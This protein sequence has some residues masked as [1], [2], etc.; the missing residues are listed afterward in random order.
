MTG[1]PIENAAVFAS[2]A[3]WISPT[4]GD[5]YSTDPPA[6]DGRKVIVSDVDHVWPKNFPQWP[7]KSFTRGLN[8]AFMDLYGATKIGDKEIE[9]L[10]F[11][12]DW[13][14]HHDVTR[15]RMGHTRALTDRIDLA[16][17]AP[18]GDLSSTGYCLAAPGR[19][20]VVYQPGAGP[21]RVKL[22]GGATFAVEWVDPET[23]EVSKGTPVR[24]NGET[25]FDALDKSEAVLHLRAQ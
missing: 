20:Y 25:T 23:G 8:T 7:W 18:R 3:D 9:S 19:E 2:P 24:S 17:M 10:R 12:G 22:E 15:R 1:A 11:V 16:A 13:L 4:G 6:A 21:F 5:G 14:A